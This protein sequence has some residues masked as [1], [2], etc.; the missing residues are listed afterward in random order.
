MGADAFATT[1]T[2]PREVFTAREASAFASEAFDVNDDARDDV[3]RASSDARAADAVARAR[4]AFARAGAAAA[5][6][7]DDVVA[8]AVRADARARAAGRAIAD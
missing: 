4:A 2:R 3:D 7:W 8:F 1:A 6:A 5:N